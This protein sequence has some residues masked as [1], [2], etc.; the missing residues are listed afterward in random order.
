MAFNGS[1][2]CW[3]PDIPVSREDEWR[4]RVAQFGDGYAQRTLDGINA[5]NRKWQVTFENREADVINAMVVYF[6]TQKG[7]AFQ[8]KEPQTGLL[9]EV[10]CDI[11]HVDWVL[12]RWDR[13]NPLAPFPY[14]YGTLTAEFVRANGVTV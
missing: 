7:S 3:I 1:D 14:Y 6:E 4:L 2:P 13:T 10:W 12:R 11:W 5:L 9:Y 8:F